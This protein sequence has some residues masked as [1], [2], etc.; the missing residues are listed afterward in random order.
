LAPKFKQEVFFDGVVLQGPLITAIAIWSKKSDLMAPNQHIRVIVNLVRF[1]PTDLIRAPK[2]NVCEKL[3]PQTL[4]KEI[5]TFLA[6][7]SVRI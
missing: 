4:I 5:H 6:T 3:N 2:T 7:Q 1:Q